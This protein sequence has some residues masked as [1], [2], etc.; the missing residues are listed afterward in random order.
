MNRNRDEN[1]NGVIDEDE[2]KWYLPS[3]IQLDFITLCHFSYEDPLLDFNRLY[4]ESQMDDTYGNQFVYLPEGN[5]SSG[6]NINSA[7]NYTYY[8]YITS[9][10][11]KVATQEMS[12][13]KFYS[14]SSQAARPGEMRC[15]R[16]L[17]DY[18]TNSDEPDLIYT[19]DN[20]RFQMKNLDSRSLRSVKVVGKELDS[21][22]NYDEENRPYKNFKVAKNLAGPVTAADMGAS[23]VVLHTMLRSDRNP[24]RTYAEDGEP[25]GTWRAPNLTELSLM[26][27][28]DN[29]KTDNVTLLPTSGSPVYACNTVWSFTPNKE[30]WGRAF[31]SRRENNMWSTTLTNPSYSNNHWQETFTNAVYIRCVKDVDP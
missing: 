31:L 20:N 27:F 6:Y 4:N 26:I 19:F 8:T 18:S 5:Y 29:L 24:C 7:V 1:G 15:V 25:A 30:V 14:F 12:N 22:T 2:M 9:D 13:T 10:Y 23:N 21:N 17:G 16:N 11:K 28:H 3:S